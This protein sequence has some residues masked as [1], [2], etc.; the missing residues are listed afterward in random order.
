MLKLWITALGLSGILFHVSTAQETGSNL[1]TPNTASVSASEH[2]L[3]LPGKTHIF[4]LTFDKPTP[5]YQGQGSITYCFTRVEGPDSSARYGVVGDPTGHCLKAEVHDGQADYPLPLTVNGDMPSGKW[6]LTGITIVGRNSQSPVSILGD[7]TFEVH[8][9]HAVVVHLEPQGSAKAG[10][11]YTLKI[12][13]DG[14]PKD[15][16]HGC[17]LTLSGSVHAVTQGGPARTVGEQT[18]IGQIELKPDLHFYE[19]TF[20][21]DPDLRSSPWQGVISIDKSFRPDPLPPGSDPG[22]AQSGR[23]Q[24]QLWQQCPLP[25]FEGQLHFAFNLEAAGLAV[26]TSATVIVNPSQIDLLRAE[27]NNLRV[28]AEHLRVQLNSGSAA[29]NQALLLKNI[30]EA[31]VDLDRTE[32]AYEERQDKGAPP[33]YARVERVFFDDIRFNYSEVLKSLRKDSALLRQTGPRLVFVDSVMGGSAPHLTPALGLGV[34]SILHEADAYYTVVSTKS[35]TFNLR[36]ISHPDGAAIS[37]KRLGDRS[38][39]T[40]P[41]ATD[42]KIENLP[43][44]VWYVLLQK[45]GYADWDGHYDGTKDSEDIL[46]AHL[47]PK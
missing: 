12:T 21:F 43:R 1:Q 6:R 2:L 40:Y 19:A 35:M 16:P 42:S 34:G 26:P 18:T 32:A 4:E 11:P 24:A 20:P 29:A 22:L 45:T 39:E 28:R 44:A 10:Q 38:Y 33:S 41:N 5:D 25:P 27:A 3:L 31:M 15:L 47:V 30:E 8:N 23:F 17:G 37:Y 46:D 36:L 14:Y 7:V 9:S 13:V